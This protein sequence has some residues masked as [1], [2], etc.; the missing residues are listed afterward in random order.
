[1]ALGLAGGRA[2]LGSARR[3][4]HGGRRRLHGRPA[5]RG[6]PRG[7]LRHRHAVPRRCRRGGG[8]HRR[9][10]GRRTAGR[11]ES[12]PPAPTRPPARRAS[13]RARARGH[14]DHRPDRAR[15]RR[16][17]PA[18]AATAPRERGLGSGDRPALLHR[19]GGVHGRERW[20]RSARRSRRHAPCRGRCRAPDGPFDRARPRERL[21]VGG[22]RVR[23]PAGAAVVDDGHDHLPACRGGRAHGPRSAAGR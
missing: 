18:R 23:A 5:A 22:S 21:D 17:E 16:R 7:S 2:T 12:S 9:P 14:C 10:R 19:L 6:C 13:R 4:R 15:R 3:S 8:R 20:R 11:D 1:M